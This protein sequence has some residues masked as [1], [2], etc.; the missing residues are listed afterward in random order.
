[1]VPA[2]FPVYRLTEMF[3]RK[4]RI[5]SDPDILASLYAR[6][7]RDDFYE[8]VDCIR[9]HFWPSLEP[10]VITDSC[11][12]L[13]GQELRPEELSRLAWRL[14]ANA[15][16]LKNGHPVLP[17]QG[18]DGYEWVPAQIINWTIGKS[19]H[20]KIGAHFDF[21]ILMGL[22]AGLKTRQF[23]TT[24]YCRVFA[25]RMG[26]DAH[27]G[28]KYPFIDVR[29]MANLRL[30]VRTLPG[31]VD[32]SFDLLG[33]PG[34]V[35]EWNRPII[36]RRSRLEFQCPRNYPFE[37]YCH[38]CPVGLDQC[39]AAVHPRSYTVKPCPGCH[40]PAWFD[41]GALCVDCTELKA[42]KGEANV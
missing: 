15:R 9:R 14:S 35:L 7:V 33:F 34:S 1:M 24:R 41:R 16:R 26:F 5:E 39:D 11:M 27:P 12:Y 29:Q 31:T 18:Q 32:L 23:W 19:R 17:W 22:A 42:I 36:K 8:F 6:L 37:Q 2:R 30:Y 20:G 25:S 38:T 21:R 4:A 10:Q 28:G 40:K 3:N 13:L